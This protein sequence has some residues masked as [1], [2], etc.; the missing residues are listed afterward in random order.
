MIFQVTAWLAALS[1][2]VLMVVGGLVRASG[3]GLG[4]PDWPLCHG[5]LVPSPD[6]AATI[7]Y[8][9]RL[10]AG[11][12]TILVLVTTTQAVRRAQDKRMFGLAIAAPLVL[13]AQIALGAVSVA[14][15]LPPF[16]VMAHLGVAFLLF[17]VLV[18]L[19]TRAVA[20][21]PDLPLS[22]RRLARLAFGAA[23]SLYL[24]ALSGAYVRAEGASAACLGWP[25]CSGTTVL[26]GGELAAI[27]ML[28]RFIAL[29]VAGHV[30]IVV[31]RGWQAG[32]GS[33]VIRVWSVALASILVLQV[34]IGAMLAS[35]G[36]SPVSQVLHV[37][38]GAASWGAAVALTGVAL[39]RSAPARERV[40]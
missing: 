5:Q 39:R 37:A 27:H 3:S 33:P 4:C 23:I 22:D 6:I 13:V 19:A 31:V 24:L 15:E 7:E 35:T 8:S 2:Y 34:A 18:L 16:V 25:L 20:P 28:H 17:G 9:H 29:L 12:T 1:T 26:A 38:G 14:F 11:L 21:W 36:V 30:M 32:D 10:L 40:G